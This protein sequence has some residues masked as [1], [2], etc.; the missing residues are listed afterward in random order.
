M[1]EAIYEHVE[2]RVHARR[3]RNV[4]HCLDLVLAEGAAIGG[5]SAVLN[6]VANPAAKRGSARR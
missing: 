1:P 2:W 5:Q 3:R 4:Q 6:A